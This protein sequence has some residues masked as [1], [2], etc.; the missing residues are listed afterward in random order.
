MSA[1]RIRG[2]EKSAGG[3]SP[4]LLVLPAQAPVRGAGEAGGGP[5]AVAAG[6]AAPGRGGV[7]V[8][9]PRRQPRAGTQDVGPPVTGDVDEPHRRIAGSDRGDL[10]VALEGARA[11]PGR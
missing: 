6:A 7:G 11:P 8:V 10:P 5:L 4:L 3:P 2:S 9:D 1:N